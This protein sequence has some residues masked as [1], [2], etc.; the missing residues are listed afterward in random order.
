MTIEPS[1]HFDVDPAP[2]KSSA[3][4]TLRIG[5]TSSSGKMEESVLPKEVIFV[6]I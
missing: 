3:A 6:K 1:L 5:I 2:K 4:D